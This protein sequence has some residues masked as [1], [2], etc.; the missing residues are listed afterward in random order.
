MRQ[1]VAAA[2]LVSQVH[3]YV[4]RMAIWGWADEGELAFDG[5]VESHLQCLKANA[6]LFVD[7][8]APVELGLWEE[9]IRYHATYRPHQTCDVVYLRSEA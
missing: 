9:V 1:V 8:G 7:A 3:I 5:S 6:A 4:K 2:R